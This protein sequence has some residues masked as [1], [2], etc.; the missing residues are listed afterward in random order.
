MQGEAPSVLRWTVILGPWLVIA[1]AWSVLLF[2]FSTQQIAFLDHDYLL[3]A[4]HL[5]WLLVL[6][7]FLLSWQM[8]IAAMMLPSLLSPLIALQR[9]PG[10]LWLNQIRF[11]AAY[12]AIWT[13][14]AVA[15]FIADTFVHWLV[16]SW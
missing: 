12:S 5:P 10:A 4:S 2:A 8:M 13:L 3:R 7:L 14:F 9:L 6:L 16:S 15:A 1:V 11:I